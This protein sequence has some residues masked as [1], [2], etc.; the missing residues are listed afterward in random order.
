MERWPLFPL[1]NA[2]NTP[3]ASGMTRHTNSFFHCI[4]KWITSMGHC[5]ISIFYSWRKKNIRCDCCFKTYHWKRATKQKEVLVFNWEINKCKT[6]FVAYLSNFLDW[7]EKQ[8][9]SLYAIKGDLLY[10]LQ[11]NAQKKEKGPRLLSESFDVLF[12]HNNQLKCKISQDRSNESNFPAYGCF[13][14]SSSFFLSV[15]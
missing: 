12:A 8:E 15:I 10:C 11:Q 3:T 1:N 5:M 2:D 6:V 9:K 4:F 13:V 7:F 14:R